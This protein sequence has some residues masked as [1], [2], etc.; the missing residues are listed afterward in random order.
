MPC[1]QVYQLVNDFLAVG[2]ADDRSLLSPLASHLA[3]HGLAVTVSAPPKPS[4][5]TP[6]STRSINAPFLVV[7]QPSGEALAC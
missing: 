4:A 2:G 7:T 5:A 1:R 3:K 6:L